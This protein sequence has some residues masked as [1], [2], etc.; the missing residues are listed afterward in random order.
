MSTAAYGVAEID[1]T[2]APDDRPVT[3]HASLT[4]PLGCTEISVDAYHCP[5]E[6]SIVL[7]VQPEQLCVPIGG[8]GQIRADHRLDV[9][10]QGIG[11]IP[12]DMDGTL[13]SDDPVDWLVVSAAVEP[14]QAGTPTVVDC[15][16]IEFSEPSTS[17][18]LTA[19]LTARLGCVGMKVNARRLKPGERVPYH[20]EGRQE[21]LFVPIVG[22]GTTMLLAGETVDLPVGWVARVPPR[23]PRSAIN[24]GEGDSIWVM[25]GAPPTGGPDD[26]DPGATVIDWPE[27]T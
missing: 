23:T 20:T 27:T 7:S 19:R 18:I 26:W 6:Q 3:A 9:P 2:L 17:S 8:S 10:P 22:E 1:A 16:E 13:T 11:F 12:G 15:S 14:E 4:E 25:V 24:T 21:E 5:A